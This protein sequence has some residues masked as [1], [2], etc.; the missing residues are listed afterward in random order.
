MR[1]GSKKYKSL[2]TRL[3]QLR[4]H[5][6]FFLP[7]PPA[8]KISY[9]EQELDST[10]AYT[11]LAHAEIEAFC[12]GLVLEKTQ[13]VKSIYDRTGK[14]RPALRRMISYHVAKKGRSW[15]DVLSPPADVV[16]SAIESYKGVIRDNHGVK[17]ENLQKLLFPIGVLDAHLDTTWL[18]QMDSFGVDRGRLAHS[19]IK[20]QQPPDPL[21]Q[22]Q[23]INQLLQGLLEMDR[24]LRR[25]R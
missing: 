24:K 14:V 9:S 4:R 8:S 3:D 7:S 1:L 22:L 15:Q 21:S 12:E 13:V 17:R 19:G 11:V 2:A 18:A 25:L 6:L 16:N 10:R 23:T 20:A 5:L